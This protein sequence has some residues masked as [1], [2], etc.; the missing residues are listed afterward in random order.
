[1][2]CEHGYTVGLDCPY[3]I[4]PVCGKPESECQPGDHDE[5]TPAQPS[6]T[7]KIRVWGIA[8]GRGS[9]QDAAQGAFTWRDYTEHDYPAQ[10]WRH[11][12]R[13]EVLRA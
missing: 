9:T 10:D 11:V 2:T 7:P 4:C 8:A 5:P 12:I 3:C 1:M 6:A 13:I